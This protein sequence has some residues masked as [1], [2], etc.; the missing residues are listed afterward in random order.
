MGESWKVYILRCGEGFEYRNANNLVNEIYAFSPDGERIF[1]ALYEDG[2]SGDPLTTIFKYEY[3]RLQKEEVF[4][5][6]SW[7]G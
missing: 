1:I 7:A 2:P 5:G 3:N 4:Y 6:L